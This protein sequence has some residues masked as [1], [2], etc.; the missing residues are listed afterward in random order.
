MEAQRDLGRHRRAAGMPGASHAG[1]VVRGGQL[2][3]L[4]GPAEG[5]RLHLPVPWHCLV[6]RARELVLCGHQRAGAG[7]RHAR[8]GVPGQTHPAASAHPPAGSPPRYLHRHGAGHAVPVPGALAQ[9]GR[10]GQGLGHRHCLRSAGPGCQPPDPSQAQAQRSWQG[11]WGRRDHHLGHPD[12]ART[13]PGRGGAVEAGGRSA[14][15]GAPQAA[16]LL[17]LTEGRRAGA[18]FGRKPPR[19]RL[20]H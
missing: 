18:A 14:L 5:N 6:H 13:R 2:G 9:P 7:L 20:L 12:L 10:R 3:P 4:D 11:R 16:G 8:R 15:R 19:A 17:P 1:G